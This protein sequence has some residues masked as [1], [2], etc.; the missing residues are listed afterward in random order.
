MWTSGLTPLFIFFLILGPNNF[1]TVI[2]SGKGLKSTQN[3]GKKYIYLENFPSI[4]QIIITKFQTKYKKIYIFLL[5]FLKF[6]LFSVSFDRSFSASDCLFLCFDF[7]CPH[8]DL[9]EKFLLV[10]PGDPL[11][12]I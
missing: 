10:A 4:S 6:S 1:D 11:L 3:F 8:K 7:K 12:I 2:D 9:V 5:A